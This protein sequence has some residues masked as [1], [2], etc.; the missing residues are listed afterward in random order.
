M[1]C[2]NALVLAVVLSLPLSAQHAE[3]Q[4]T[5]PVLSTADLSIQ[6][7]LPKNVRAEALYLSLK[8]TIGRELFIEERGGLSSTPIQN[9]RTLGDTVIIYDTAEYGQRI[10]G[11]CE[12]LDRATAKSEAGEAV[13]TISYHPRH[14]GLLAAQDLLRPFFS[15]RRDRGASLVVH[16]GMVVMHDSHSRLEEMLALLEKADQPQPQ[17][18]VT[19]Y[20]LAGSPGHDSQGVPAELVEHLGRLIPDTGFRR[21]GFAMLQSSVAPSGMV[22]LKFDGPQRTGYTFSFFPS[23]FD[24]ETNSMTLQPCSLEWTGDEESTVIFSTSTLLRGDEYTVLGASGADPVFLA[25]RISPVEI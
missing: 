19:C 6:Q 20:L 18:L 21:V 3:R 12:K 5:E 15:S 4:R 16:G 25:V 23:A 10:L 17:V 14:M 2:S 9:L 22:K 1:K 11:M 7:Y 13:S 24:P 8:N